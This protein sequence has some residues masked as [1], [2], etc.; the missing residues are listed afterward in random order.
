MAILLMSS[1][2]SSGASHGASTG[3]MKQGHYEM[4]EKHFLERCFTEAG[5]KC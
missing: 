5:K 2:K 4:A 3:N 1:R